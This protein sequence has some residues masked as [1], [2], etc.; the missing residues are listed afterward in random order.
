VG[1]ADSSVRDL[2]I[3]RF[4]YPQPRLLAGL[5]LRG[6]ASA[7]IDISDGLHV[8]LA[9]LLRDSR[10]G[11]LLDIATIP[12]S[13]ALQSSVDRARA[14]ELALCGGEDYELCYTIAP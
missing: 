12:L 9:R 10:V 11:A 2:L 6:V 5:N 7:M 4:Y 1:V 3:E 8:D 13:A 14:V